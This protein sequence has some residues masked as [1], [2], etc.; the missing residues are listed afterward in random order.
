MGFE[1][2]MRELGYTEGENLVIEHRFGQLD[3]AQLRAGAQE[4]AHLR[5]DAIFASGEPAAIAALEATSDIP[6]VITV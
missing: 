6:I 4:L 5:V 3:P 2:G 1:A